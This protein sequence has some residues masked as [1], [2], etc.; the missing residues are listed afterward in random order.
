ML[1]FSHAVWMV[2]I[3]LA[4]INS[5]TRSAEGAAAVGRRSGHAA[6]AREG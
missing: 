3:G 4:C 6:R 2:T 1:S 5:W